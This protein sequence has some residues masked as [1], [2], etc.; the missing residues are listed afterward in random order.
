MNHPRQVNLP[1]LVAPLNE[2]LG[3]VVFGSRIAVLARF[4]EGYF[5]AWRARHRPAEI[6]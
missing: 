1:N 4:D 2:H 3:Q 6:T 5:A